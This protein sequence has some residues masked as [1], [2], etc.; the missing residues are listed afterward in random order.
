MDSKIENI[1]LLRSFILKLT[2]QDIYEIK[3]I[4]LSSAQKSRIAAWCENN[5]ISIPDLDNPSFWLS[6]DFSSVKAAPKLQMNFPDNDSQFIGIDIQSI[7]EFTKKLGDIDKNNKELALIFTDHEISYAESK[8]NPKETI[9]GIY[10]AKEAIL[11][12]MNMDA[13]NWKEI[14]IKYKN[15]KPSFKSIAINISH[16]K[17]FAIAIAFFQKNVVTKKILSSDNKKS[18]DP[19]YLIGNLGGIAF[20][21]YLIF[22]IIF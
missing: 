15:G 22:F 21:I 5:S 1:D 8:A 10:A 4:S 6:S 19:V 3:E 16:S 2:D 13:K 11:K 9:T 17:D 14:E 12:C 7:S 20:L 18:F